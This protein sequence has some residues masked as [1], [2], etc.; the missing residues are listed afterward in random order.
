MINKPTCLLIFTAT[1]AGEV[2][3]VQTAEGAV[4]FYCLILCLRGRTKR[5]LMNAH[6]LHIFSQQIFPFPPKNISSFEVVTV[7]PDT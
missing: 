3:G 7:W 5:R 4:G 2:G 6:A 1:A